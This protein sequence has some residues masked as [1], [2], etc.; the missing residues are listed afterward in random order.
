MSSPVL[1]SMLSPAESTPLITS[2]PPSVSMMSMPAPRLIVSLPVPVLIVPP[3]PEAVTVS[4]PVAPEAERFSKLEYAPA[5][6]VVGERSIV[7]AVP[8][9]YVSVSLPVPPS[10]EAPPTPSTTN[11]KLSLPAWRLIASP[12]STLLL[13][14]S[15]PSPALTV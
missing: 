11:A 6:A 4:A 12:A 10:T 14:T 5:A 9:E 1:R 2:A 3:L 7:A 15:E 13:T 8:P